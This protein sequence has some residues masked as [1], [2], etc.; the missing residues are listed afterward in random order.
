[1]KKLFTLVLLL[2]NTASFGQNYYPLIKPNL[3]WQILHGDGAYIC[4]L[5][6]GHQYYFQGDTLISGITYQKI[7]SNPIIALNGTPYCPPF[8]VDGNSPA[9]LS[10]LMREDTV[11]RKVFIYNFNSTYE[12]LIYDFNLI[13]GDTLNSSYAGMGSVVIVDS[14]STISLLNGSLRKIFYLN[15]GE[16]YVESIGGSQGI[17]FPLIQGLGFWEIPICISENNTPI[18]GGQCFGTVGINENLQQAELIYPNPFIDK[19][20][21]KTND[22]EESQFII[23]DNLSKE[24]FSQ[25]FIN[26]S[27]FNLE[28]LKIGV[29]TY[30]M[31][32]KSGSSSF[33]K[34]VK[35]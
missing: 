7:R 17:Q 31:I 27:T 6:D 15:T 16:N 4:D 24:L 35:L 9:F 30:K 25:A 22:L 12:E 28:H 14:V 20:S 1:M 21:I 26:S 29:Y 2:A 8:A 23:Y 10:G 11:T 13:A 19:I 3:V 32:R 18:W 5:R 34:I 33:G